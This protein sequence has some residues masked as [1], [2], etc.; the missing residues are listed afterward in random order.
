MCILLNTIFMA[1]HD[2]MKN[3]EFGYTFANFFSLACKIWALANDWEGLLIPDP[4]HQNAK[5]VLN[6]MILWH[7]T[8]NRK[9]SYM[10][11]GRQS[12]KWENYTL[13]EGVVQ[14]PY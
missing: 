6:A 13:M 14:P 7:K 4:D 5:Q 9:I 12:K 8:Q 10:D 2:R 3:N 1:F 11:V